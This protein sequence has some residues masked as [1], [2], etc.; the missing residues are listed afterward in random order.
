MCLGGINP[1]PSVCDTHRLLKSMWWGKLKKAISCKI[2]NVKFLAICQNASY[3]SIQWPTFFVNQLINEV[4]RG[5]KVTWPQNAQI[6]LEIGYR[7]LLLH[8]WMNTNKHAWLGS[9]WKRFSSCRRCDTVRVLVYQCK[10]SR[11]IV[12]CMSFQCGCIVRNYPLSC[13]WEGN[14]GFGIALDNALQT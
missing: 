9:F 7:C 4:S 10:R 2:L 1:L 8:R 11:E 14:R 13:S 6:I 5:Q 12:Y 3:L